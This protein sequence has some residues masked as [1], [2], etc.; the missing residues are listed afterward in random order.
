MY[1]IYYLYNIIYV[2]VV[3]QYYQ[4]AMNC[5]LINSQ[6]VT[7]SHKKSASL[8]LYIESAIPALL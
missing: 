5:T 1:Q 2:S 4:P 7:Y 3:F 8:L 6:N